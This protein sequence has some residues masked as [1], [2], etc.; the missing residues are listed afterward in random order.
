MRFF[1][2]CLGSCCFTSLHFSLISPPPPCKRRLVGVVYQWRTASDRAVSAAIFRAGEFEAALTLI[3]GAKG[4]TPQFIYLPGMGLSEWELKH[5][6]RVLTDEAGGGG[7]HSLQRTPYLPSVCLDSDQT[8]ALIGVHHLCRQ[9][10]AHYH[11]DRL[12]TP[13]PPSPSSNVL[14]F[15]YVCVSTPPDLP[16]PRPQSFQFQ[17]L[18][19]REAIMHVRQHLQPRRLQKTFLWK[20]PVL[21]LIMLTAVHDSRTR[22]NALHD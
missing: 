3:P 11:L 6:I 12:L 7:A 16:L 2:C 8:A 14:L 4:W 21:L 9:T 20:V 5:Q 18:T 17:T 10:L 15:Q 13:P 1:S 22:A 19:L